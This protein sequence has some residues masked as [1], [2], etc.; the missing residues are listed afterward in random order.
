MKH[1][2]SIKPCYSLLNCMKYLFHMIRA[3]NKAAAAICSTALCHLYSVF[4][5]TRKEI[6]AK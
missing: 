3:N 5:M 1:E 4:L 2:T 6:A